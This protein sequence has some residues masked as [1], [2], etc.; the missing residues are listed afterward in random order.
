[1][2]LGPASGSA[3]KLTSQ[4]D[5]FWDDLSFCPRLHVA[6]GFETAL[7]LQN[8]GYEPI[9]ALGDSGHIRQFPVLFGVGELVICADNDVPKK[10]A[11]GRTS[12]RGIEA[13]EVCAQRWNMSTHQRA[14]IW[15]RNH[16]GDDFADP[17]VAHG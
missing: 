10:L 5:T 17:V 4:F 1:M 12:R 16:A 6:E 11:N 13:A 15:L 3:M 2:M 9:W 7:S 14:V 8:Q